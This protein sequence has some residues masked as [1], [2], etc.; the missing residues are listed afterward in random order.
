MISP[1]Y[2]LGKIVMSGYRRTFPEGTSE[3]MRPLPQSRRPRHPGTQPGRKHMGRHAREVLRQHRILVRGSRRKQTLRSM[4]PLRNSSSG[5]VRSI[6]AFSSIDDNQEKANGYYLSMQVGIS[7]RTIEFHRANIKKKLN[8]SM[9]AE[10]ISA[11]SEI[12]NTSY[13]I[14][15]RNR[16]VVTRG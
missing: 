9:L 15:A 10:V 3:R 14:T 2:S 4:H 5:T 7:A 16:S 1:C 8:V 11:Y 12:A 13:F 6:T